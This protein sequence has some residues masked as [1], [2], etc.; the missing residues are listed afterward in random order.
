MAA[1]KPDATVIYVPPPG[2]AAAILEALESEVPLIVC[3]TEGIPQQVTTT[4]FG[5]KRISDKRVFFVFR[6]WCA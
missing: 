6:I 5:S 1:T 4:L 2:A 3:I